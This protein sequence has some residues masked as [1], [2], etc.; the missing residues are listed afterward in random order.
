MVIVDRVVFDH[1][2]AAPVCRSDHERIAT[3]DARTEPSAA[4]PTC[5]DQPPPH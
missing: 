5:P 2:I 3:P 4:D 1:L